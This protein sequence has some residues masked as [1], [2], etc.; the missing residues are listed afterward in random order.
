MDNCLSKF[1]LRGLN[2]LFQ[3]LCVWILI[4]VKVRIFVF[5]FDVLDKDEF[6]KQRKKIF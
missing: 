4:R 1:I 3:I 6:L 2:Y 5:Y